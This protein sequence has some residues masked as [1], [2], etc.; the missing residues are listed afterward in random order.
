MFIASLAPYKNIDNYILNTPNKV[1]DTL[2]LGLPTLTPL[3]GE[4]QSLIDNYKVGYVYGGK[5]TLT[6]CVSSLW[7]DRKLQDEMSSNAR[8]LY[9]Q[10][11]EFNL[12]MTI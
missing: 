2:S 4:V 3:T 11:F 8:N 12:V 1:V 6:E 7:S 10:S 9:G 5:L